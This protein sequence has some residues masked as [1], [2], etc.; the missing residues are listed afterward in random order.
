MH[1]CIDTHTSTH[2]HLTHA[3]LKHAYLKGPH[4]QFNGPP[5][6][7]AHAPYACTHRI[8]ARTNLVHGHAGA[9]AY[10]RTYGHAQVHLHPHAPSTPPRTPSRHPGTL[11]RTRLQAL[12]IVDEG[13]GDG[14]REE[15]PANHAHTP[16][17]T[18]RVEE[19]T[20]HMRRTPANHAHKPPP[21]QTTLATYQR[22]QHL[23]YPRP[24]TR[25]HSI[26]RA[27]R[28]IPAPGAHG[29]RLGGNG[30]TNCHPGHTNCDPN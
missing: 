18:C 3:Q 27:P 1:A 6:V 29:T 9:R 11:T 25:P 24:D 23:P 2:Q 8:R 14:K 13:G 7:Y 19:D 4:K 28:S 12:N 15:A 22:L 17:S 20:C 26:R 5:H 10:A 21:H 16:S 30:H